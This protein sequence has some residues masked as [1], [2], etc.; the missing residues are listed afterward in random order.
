MHSHCSLYLRYKGHVP[1]LKFD[2][3]ETY[4]NATCKM[5][6]DTRLDVLSQS[7]T[8][9][10]N[11]GTFPTFYTHNPELVLDARTRTRDRFLYQP[12]YVLYNTDR[13][14]LRELKT[15]DKVACFEDF[16]R[17]SWFEFLPFSL[18]LSIYFLSLCRSRKLT[19]KITKTKAEHC[20]QSIT[21]SSR[22]H[23]DY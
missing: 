8:Q 23:F 13:D 9:Y 14:R 10:A 17:C 7:K 16:L 21:S 15:F 4:G 12:N 2:M 19:E 20:L 5:L 3:G 1:G 6:E 11:G 18:F 22:N